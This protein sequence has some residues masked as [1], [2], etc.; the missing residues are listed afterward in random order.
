MSKSVIF[1]GSFDPFTVGHEALVYR[2]L[3]LFDKVYIAIGVNSEKK[4]MFSTETRVDMISDVFRN[5][6]RIEV[7]CYE[8]L[9]IDLCRT[10]NVFYL[11]RGLRTSADF[12]FE[13]AIGQVNKQL[14]PNIETVFMLVAPEH[15][16]VSS[17][18]VRDI[19]FHQGDASQF[20]SKNIDINN[21]KREY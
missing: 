19:I 20:L 16:A 7:I 4:Y 15:S 8:G 18:V 12:E 14:E 10:L 3:E 17:S 9:T 13:R 5:D 2:T 1:P 21:Y 6:S 11:V